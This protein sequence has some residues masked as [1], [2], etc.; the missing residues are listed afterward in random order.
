V[1]LLERHGV[2][3]REAIRGEGIA[4]GFAGMYPV[5][6]VMEEA[7]SVRRGYFVAGLG[8]AQFAVPGAVDRLRAFRDTPT[9]PEV[10]VLAATDPA[11]AYGIALPWPVKGPQRAAGAYVVLVDGQ[12]SLYIEKG[13]R[14]LVALR[15]FDGTWE[16]HAV[17]ALG[18]LVGPD[19]RPSARFRKLVFETYPADLREVL[20]QAGFV[21]TP[22]GLARYA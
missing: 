8:G 4:G 21:A 18:A 16:S 20:N 22:K 11:N 15:P 3:T 9:D 19:D 5:L 2:L 14:S 6:K 12:P 17:G 13:G 10:V 1:S 7:G